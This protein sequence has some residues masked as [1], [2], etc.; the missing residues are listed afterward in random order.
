MAVTV[1]GADREQLPVRCPPPLGHLLL[2][3]VLE[4]KPI[5]SLHFKPAQLA[6]I[7]EFMGQCSGRRPAGTTF[8]RM[9]RTSSN[10]GNFTQE[11]SQR[12]FNHLAYRKQGCQNILNHSCYKKQKQTKNFL[13]VSY[14]GLRW[15]YMLK[16]IYLSSQVG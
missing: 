4:L 15:S 13:N 10:K 14:V 5:S 11:T 7:L 1:P 9:R 2:S 16:L 3:G 8:K 12:A 6:D